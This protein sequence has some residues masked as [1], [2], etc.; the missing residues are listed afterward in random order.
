MSLNLFLLYVKD[1]CKE[2]SPGLIEIEKGHLIACHRQTKEIKLLRK[3]YADNVK[4][5]TEN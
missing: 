1:I 3:E 5:S 2:Q 4:A